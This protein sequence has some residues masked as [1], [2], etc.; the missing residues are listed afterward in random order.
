MSTSGMTSSKTW[1]AC[2]GLCRLSGTELSSIAGFWLVV[3]IG[4]LLFIACGGWW[5]VDVHCL[6]RT[7]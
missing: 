3:V 6:R 7:L 4:G 2:Q 1:Q 5:T